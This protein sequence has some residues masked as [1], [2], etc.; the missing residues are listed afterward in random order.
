MAGADR[1]LRT[2]ERPTLAIILSWMGVCALLVAVAWQNI[3][4][5]RFPGPDDS[6][7]LVQVRDLLAGQSWFDLNQYRMTPPEGTLMHWSRLVDAPI[8]ALVWLLA[9]FTDMASAER[10]AMIAMP[11]IVLLFT[12]LVVGR[13]AWRLFDRQTAIYACLALPILPLVAMQFQPLRI[14]HHGWQIFTVVLAAWACSW[15]RGERGG[16]VAGIA[17]AV[18]LMIS[19]EVVFMAASFGAILALRWLRDR[20]DRWWLVSYL[21]ALA[22]GLFVLFAAARG[23]PDLAAH[24]DVIAPPH[25][26]FFI[27]V[28]LGAGMLAV[29]PPMPRLPLALTLGGFGLLGLG[30]LAWAAPQCLA[31]PFAG[32]D[33]LVRD[34]WYLNVTEGRPAWQNDALTAVPMLIQLAIALAVTLYLASVHREWLRRF[35]FEYAA[36][37][38]AA[39][40][41]GA[42]TF[43]SLAFAG[44]LAALPMGWLIGRMFKRWRSVDG[45]L[46]KLALALALYFALLPSFP[47]VLASKVFGQTQERERAVVSESRCKLRDNARLLN[48]LQPATLLAPLDIGPALLLHTHHGVVASGHHRAEQA[49]R[50]VI[51]AFLSPAEVARRHAEAYGADY[52][53]VC[54]DLMEPRVLATGGGE[55]GLMSRLMAGDPPAWLEPV[56]VGGPDELKVWRVVGK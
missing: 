9:Q 43:R 6:L 56:D 3:A 26:G 24:C 20:K 17:M 10:A 42:L 4:E 7:R 39:T 38:A 45:L 15:R 33:P 2:G 16:A 32:L 18:G 47:I 31:P 49:M 28:A 34:Y 54:S 35:W 12:M 40:L 21:Q 46:S 48:R 53:V 50:D 11:L 36:L 5:N 22:L 44:A 37:L 52:V 23:L 30:F 14:D 55:A 1:R 41:F 25:I 13:M 29:A 19:L 27:I 51:H 8:A